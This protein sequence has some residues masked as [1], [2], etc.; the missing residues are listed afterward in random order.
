VRCPDAD[1][2]SGATA[3]ATVGGRKRTLRAAAI[4]PP[5]RGYGK[6]VLRLPRIVRRELADE[7]DM[8]A[9]VTVCAADAAANASTRG[10]AVL[11]RP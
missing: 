1:C 7:G 9:R 10:R 3:T 11:L 4:E 8:R 5:E 6:L 2:L